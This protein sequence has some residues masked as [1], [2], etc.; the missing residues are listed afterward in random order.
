MQELCRTAD[1]G[2][3]VAV[4]VKLK[5]GDDAEAVAQRI[6]QHTGAGGRADEREGRQVDFDGTGGGSFAYHNVEPVVFERGIEDFFDNGAEAVDFVDK[7]YVVRI[8]IGQK[9]GEVAGA[10]EDG[11][12]GLAQIY[13]QFFGDD[14]RQCGFTQP[15]RAEEQDVVERFAALFGGLDEDGEL[16]FGFMLPDVVVQCFGTEGA[17]EQFFLCGSGLGGNN[18]LRLRGGQVVGLQ[19]SVPFVGY[20]V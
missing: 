11:A 5:A 2:G 13:A 12:A 6:G 9:G 1:D 10:F 4:F 14:V 17:F 20:A 19:H 16:L 8:K 7:Q 15:R 18:A 3:E